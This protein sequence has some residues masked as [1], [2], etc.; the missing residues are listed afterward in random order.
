[1]ASLLDGRSIRTEHMP[2]Y[3]RMASTLVACWHHVGRQPCGSLKEGRTV[4]KA[5]RQASDMDTQAS[6]AD[7][8]CS[9]YNLER[10][11]F[12]CRLAAVMHVEGRTSEATVGQ[13]RASSQRLLQAD[14]R[15]QRRVALGLG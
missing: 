10:V 15:A 6:H 14:D 5:E 13:A 11:E 1:M 4:Q 12:V 8:A 2:V 9:S 3:V 7:H